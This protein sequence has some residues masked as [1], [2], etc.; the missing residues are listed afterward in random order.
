[1]AKDPFFDAVLAGQVDPTVTTN[2]QAVVDSLKVFPVR[3]GKSTVEFLNLQL[4]GDAVAMPAGPLRYAVG[5]QFWRE[6]LKD[7]PDP[8]TQAGEVF[9]SIQQSAVDAK[10]NVKAVFGELSVPVLT[11]LEAQLAIRYDKYPNASETS[12][13]VAAKYTPIPELAFRAHTPRASRRRR[14]S[15]SS[16]PRRKAPAR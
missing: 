2:D 15:S 11:N 3:K 12:P 8:L 1:M 16:A 13:K 5:A 4:S 6:K 7:I 10:R 14:S 9:G